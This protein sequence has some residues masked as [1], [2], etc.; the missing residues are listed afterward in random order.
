MHNILNMI[1]QQKGLGLAETLVA[2]AILGTTVVAFI[3]ALSAG[4]IAVGA[5][6]EEVIIQGLARSQLEH[7]KSYTYIPGTGSYPTIAV[8]D[9]YALEVAVSTI[10]GTDNNIQ[11]I[12]VSVSRESQVLL[13]V[14]DYKVNR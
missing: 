4:T 9:N 14:S 3:A 8:P 2:V 1:Q 7:T 5:Q 6:D 12:T 11:K 10:P 13:T